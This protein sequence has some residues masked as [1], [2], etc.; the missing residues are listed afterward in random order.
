GRHSRSSRC[1]GCPSR[2]G[3]TVPTLGG[4]S[5]SCR[6]RPSPKGKRMS[7]ESA[8]RHRLRRRNARVAVAAA[9]ARV[10]TPRLVLAPAPTPA[11][12][13]S[14]RF[15]GT[16]VQASKLNDSAY[17]TILNREFNQVTPENEMKIDA[18]EPTQGNCQ[19]GPSDQIV[20]YAQ[21]HGMIVRGHTLAW[22]S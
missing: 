5:A 13:Q 3:V 4:G 20:A 9:A 17:T 10:L 14:G 21:A 18:T 16:A 12:A 11:A 22:H 15:F 2:S 19:F 7:T 1:D 8:P 6:Q